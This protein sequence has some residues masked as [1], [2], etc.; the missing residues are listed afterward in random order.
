[1][2]DMQQENLGRDNS[3]VPKEEKVDFIIIDIEALRERYKNFLSRFL[4]WEGR[5][6]ER[7]NRFLGFKCKVLY[8]YMLLL[9]V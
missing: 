8:S 3:R 4:K 1:L 2:H 5:E 6:K 7:I 9:K